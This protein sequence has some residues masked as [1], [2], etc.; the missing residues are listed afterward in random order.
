[1]PLSTEVDFLW[2]PAKWVHS[3]IRRELI[4]DLLK[5]AEK[6]EDYNARKHAEF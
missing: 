1:M 6:R 4:D 5:E 3:T 2:C